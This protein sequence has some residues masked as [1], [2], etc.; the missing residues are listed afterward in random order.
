MEGVD[1]LRDAEDAMPLHRGA[2]S[3]ENEPL[4]RPEATIERDEERAQL[5]RIEFSIGHPASANLLNVAANA[6][7]V[8]R[9]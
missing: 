3:Y 2:P 1:I 9:I 8:I 6:S 7:S 5:A 4:L